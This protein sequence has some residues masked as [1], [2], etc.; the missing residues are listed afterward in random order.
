MYY[1]GTGVDSR[2]QTYTVIVTCTD[3]ATT[4]VESNVT[5]VTINVIKNHAPVFTNYPSGERVLYNRL[6][7]GFAFVCFDVQTT[8]DQKKH[9]HRFYQAKP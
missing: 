7:A 8:Y 6:S 9:V 4:P 2:V 3:D 1:T 5:M